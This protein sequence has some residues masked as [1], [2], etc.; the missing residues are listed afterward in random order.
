[1]LIFQALLYDAIHPETHHIHRYFLLLHFHWHI[2]DQLN[3]EYSQLPTVH[4]N[5]YFM[6]NIHDRGAGVFLLTK[7]QGDALQYLFILLFTALELGVLCW[8]S[9]RISTQV[10][11]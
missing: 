2:G 1:M 9:E 11:Q 3:G 6:Q 10:H 4:R 7:N 8:L 5:A